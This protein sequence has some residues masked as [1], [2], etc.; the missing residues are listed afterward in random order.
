MPSYDYICSSCKNVWTEFKKMDN[1]KEPE[2]NPCPNC[3]VSGCV[4]Q[5]IAFTPLCMSASLEATRAM[6]KLNNSEFGDKLRQIHR[7]SPGSVMD[8]HSSFVDI[9]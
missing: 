3:N 5:T 7:D 4:E 6:R 9:K 1:R 8:K 2:S